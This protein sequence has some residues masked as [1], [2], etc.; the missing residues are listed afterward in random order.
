[1]TSSDGYE[2]T[3]TSDDLFNISDNE[4]KTDDR[5]ITP[6]SSP[7]SSPEPSPEPEQPCWGAAEAIEQGKFDQWATEAYWNVEM[8]FVPYH[9]LLLPARLAG[10]E[11][12]EVPSR[13]KPKDTHLTVVNPS[14]MLPKMPYL[15]RSFMGCLTYDNFDH[16]NNQ[17]QNMRALGIEEKEVPLSNGEKLK[18][19]LPSFNRWVCQPNGMRNSWTMV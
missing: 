13:P 9:R 16:K 1:M 11:G 18:L 10:W 5:E 2:S 4:T 12:E 7:E 19:V 15:E 14:R 8:G 17:Q 3:E 6:C